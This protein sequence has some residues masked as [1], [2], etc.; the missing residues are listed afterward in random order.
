MAV[1]PPSGKIALMNRE[2]FAT[3]EYYHIYNRGVDKRVTFVNHYDIDRFFQS[4]KIFNSVKP[5]GSL[6]EKSFELN[7]KSGAKSNKPLVNI[8]CYCLNPNH[9]HLILEQLVERGISEFM[10]R[11]NG[12]YTWYFN[13]RHKRSGTLF[14]GVFKSKLIKNNDY[15]LHL[16]AYVNL[17]NRV[18]QL[19]GETAKLSKS[20]FNEYMKKIKG[21]SI[22]K[23]DVI[24]NQFKGPKDYKKFC[25]EALDAMVEKKIEDKE[26]EL[27][28][29]EN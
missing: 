29:L 6:Y 26:L 20:S 11:V 21:E 18:H 7:K 19:G 15:L 10:K 23:T 14:Q 5:I 4:L 17:N 16:S 25:H 9:Y 13:N 22:C 8:I 1:S 28:L 27:L 24:L 3:G 12:G 2:P